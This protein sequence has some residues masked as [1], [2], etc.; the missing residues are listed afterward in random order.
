MV[1]QRREL[2]GWMSRGLTACVGGVIGVPAVKYVLSTFRRRREESGFRRVA[3]VNDLKAGKPAL[4]VISGSRQDAWVKHEKQ[5][6]GRVWLVR[7]GDQPASV[8]TRVTAFSSICPHMGCQVHFQG[9]GKQFVCPCHR[10]IFAL[11]G[12]PVSGSGEKTKVPRGLD[13]LECRVVQEEGSSEW[14]VEVKYEKF[15]LGLTEKVAKS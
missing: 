4:V 12:A 13:Q 1:M 15:E 8:G 2:L 6:L 10:G 7:E 14:W 11:S 3:R 9:E 5:P